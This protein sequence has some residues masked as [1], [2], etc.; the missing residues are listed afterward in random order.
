LTGWLRGL[1]Q[2]RSSSLT[3]VTFF[4]KLRRTRRLLLI[5]PSQPQVDDPNFSILFFS[6]NEGDLIQSVRLVDSGKLESGL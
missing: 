2:M 1:L 4:D 6:T 5:V 3:S